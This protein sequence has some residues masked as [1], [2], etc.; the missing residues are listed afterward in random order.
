MSHRLY[1]TPA[2]VLARGERGESST[3]LSLLSPRFGLVLAR[4][5]GLRELR[6][7]LRYAL[8]T[9]ALAEVTLVRGR[10][11]WRLVN[12]RPECL[13]ASPAAAPAKY[14]LLCRLNRLLLR[15]IRGERRE[16]RLFEELVAGLRFVAATDLSPVLLVRAELALVL[17]L[18]DSLGYV[19]PTPALA[20]WRS[21]APWSVTALGATEPASE[22]VTATINHALAQSQL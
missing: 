13:L 16:A 4:A 22:L 9:G 20:P 6:S 1:T 15:L 5:Q 3:W 10:E 18:L 19:A 2:L 17:R 8:P 21:L 7:K 11:S 12:A 14:E